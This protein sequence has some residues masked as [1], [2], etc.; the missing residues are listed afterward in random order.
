MARITTIVHF[1]LP[2]EHIDEFLTAWIKIKDFM[3]GQ[4]GA[5][6]GT[7]HRSIDDD[8]PFQI[9]NVAHWTSPET[10]AN[11]LRASGEEFKS[12]GTDLT[13]L[14]ALRRSCLPKQLY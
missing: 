13:E 3:L 12:R 11:A 1:S 14:W 9:V 8:S 4:P 10:L 2:K 6:D 5:L 7:L